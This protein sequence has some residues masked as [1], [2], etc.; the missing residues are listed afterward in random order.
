IANIL[1]GPLIRLAP[2]IA[3]ALAPGGRLVLSGLLPNQ[4]ARVVAAYGGQGVRL[5]RAQ[6]HDGWMILEL[7]RPQRTNRE[8]AGA[9]LAQHP[10]F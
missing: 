7:R 3:P 6:E 5:V 10:A 2:K 8:K 4:R 9:A 1:A